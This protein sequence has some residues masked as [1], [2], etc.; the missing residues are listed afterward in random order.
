MAAQ[1]S[2]ARGAAPAPPLVY[3]AKIHAA[4]RAKGAEAQFSDEDEKLLAALARVRFNP[5]SWGAAFW[6]PLHMWS[7]LRFPMHPTEAQRRHAAEALHD[8]FPGMLPCSKC[9]HHLSVNTQD[10]YDHTE[11]GL[12]FFRYLVDLHNWV[13]VNVK[14]IRPLTYEEAAAAYS[15][16]QAIAEALRS[17]TSGA[18]RSAATGAAAESN[19]SFLLPLLIVALV[20]VCAALAY[21]FRDRILGAFSRS[22]PARVRRDWIRDNGLLRRK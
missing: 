9:S 6:T 12:R 19:E 3:F 16:T 8:A 20:L 22:P 11:T 2:E 14:K 10:A 17:A 5:K 18:Q 21:F 7:I 4:R 1:P 13:N 15:D